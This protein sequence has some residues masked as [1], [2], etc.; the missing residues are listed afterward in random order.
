M[1]KDEIVRLSKVVV[2]VEEQKEHFKHCYEELMTSSK[3][4][5]EEMHGEIV[6]LQCENNEKEKALKLAII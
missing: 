3:L 2:S 5:E 6:K 4:M 1:M